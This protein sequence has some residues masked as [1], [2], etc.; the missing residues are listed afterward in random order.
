MVG[1][2]ADGYAAEA[3][4]YGDVIYADTTTQPVGRSGCA[5]QYFWEV[6]LCHAL[7]SLKS[8]LPACC[9]TVSDAGGSRVGGHNR[10]ASTAM[11]TARGQEGAGE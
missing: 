6:I 2:C 8:P 9:T 7:L 5:T 3:N 4:T 10:S 11:A 1:S